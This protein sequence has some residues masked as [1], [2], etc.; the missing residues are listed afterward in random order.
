MYHGMAARS[1]YLDDEGA[2]KRL[3]NV[4]SMDFQMR[5]EFFSKEDA[6]LALNFFDLALASIKPSLFETVTVHDAIMKTAFVLKGFQIKAI[7]DTHKLRLLLKTGEIAGQM[8]RQA[9]EEETGST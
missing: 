9:V 5:V 3:V 2:S 7:Q 1:V 8:W 4:N 6:V